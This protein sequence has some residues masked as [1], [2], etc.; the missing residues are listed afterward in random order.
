MAL[1][2]AIERQRRLS[3]Y[4]FIL[5]W[6]GGFLLLQAVPI[7]WGLVMSF[8]NRS[9]FGRNL[10]FVGVENYI[11]LLTDPEVLYSFWTTLVF[12]ISS[13]LLAVLLGLL[14][15]LLLERNVPGRGAF[16]TLLFFPYLIPLV[17]VG[18]IFRIFLERDTGFLNV[19]LMNLGVTD[20][21][22]PWL[23]SFPRAS[24]IVLLIWMSGWSMIIFLG[25]LS[26]VPNELHEVAT[27]DGARYFRRLRHITLPLLSPFI[28]F[29]L[30]MSFIYA[31]QEFIRPFIM[32]PRPMR[33]VQLTD[34]APPPETFF[35]MAKAYHTIVGQHRFALGLALLW[36]LFVAVLVL[37]MLFL[38]FGGVWVYSEVEDKR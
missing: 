16:R 22:V 11:K 35:V 14:F 4:T 10:R 23:A 3:F 36:I 34:S 32:N 31:M 21:A 17:A 20:R 28:L 19:I 30:V 1:R 27:M 5:P 9:A 26:T 2:S 12:T 13:T 38:R 15:A 18:W 6:L 37:T 25:G 33:G 7:G 24:M 8:T 29:Q